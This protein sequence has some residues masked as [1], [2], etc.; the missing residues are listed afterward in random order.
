VLDTVD[1]LL[2]QSRPA[3]EVLVVDDASSD[4]DTLDALRVLEG[5]KAVRV[6]R[7]PT[8]S[9]V[10]AAR[11]RGIQESTGDAFVLLDGDDM[12]ERQSLAAFADALDSDPAAGFAYPTVRTFGNRNDVFPAPR[13]N[14]Y[15]LHRVNICPIASMVRRSVPEAGIHFA[16]N[17]N[18]EDW[19][20]WLR[21]A[22][23][24]FLG[25]A[26]TDAV[27]LWRRWGFT[28]LSE[29]TRGDGL[30]APIRRQRPELFEPA[31]LTDIK[32]AWA[33]EV[34]I[35]TSSH[36]EASQAPVGDY[37][38][39]APEEWAGALGRHV[40]L[41]RGPV[42]HLFSDEL[43]I[44][45]L[46]NATEA[47]EFVLLVEPSALHAPLP[48]GT[49]LDSTDLSAGCVLAADVTGVSVRRASPS[50]QALGAAEDVWGAAIEAARRRLRAHPRGVTFL[51]GPS[52]AEPPPRPDTAAHATSYGRP[53]WM[54]ELLAGLPSL[55]TWRTALEAGVGGTSSLVTLRHVTDPAGG[56][57][58]FAADEDLPVG[59]TQ[60]ESVVS[61]FAESYH[62]LEA[63][64]RVVLPDHRR[65]V[66]V[67]ASGDVQIEALLGYVEA[68]PTPGSIPLCDQ[69]GTVLGWA[70]PADNRAPMEGDPPALGTQT[71]L[72]RGLDTRTGLRRYGSVQSLAS[73]PGVRIE[74]VAVWLEQD[75]KPGEPWTALYALLDDE[76]MPARGIGSP[77]TPR[78]SGLRLGTKPLGYLLGSPAA[79]A[80]EVVFRRAKANG[81]ILCTTTPDEGSDVGFVTECSLGFE[82]G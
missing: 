38:L 76:A 59:L 77:S 29:A 11:N 39:V 62:G 66:A 2:R 44:E 1:S 6:L 17:I 43:A 80:R 14:L 41:V 33:P 20:Y 9:G 53:E 57:S 45:R 8:N 81:D 46:L 28:R 5:F 40:M 72:W 18:P 25:I 67:E 61:V 27:L 15:A 37:E 47:S 32:S 56:V 31:R 73:L 60:G 74:K 50:W 10:S 71:P 82:P 52:S 49:R 63:L 22:A 78:P 13:F 68:A 75:P 70:Y 79:G 58:L 7:Q 69:Q 55:T 36:R 3:S 35:V 16:D 42:D 12:F 21:A 19:D 26:A 64:Y 24:G 4:R 48:V 23:A 51:V 30:E 54:D 34:S 65:G